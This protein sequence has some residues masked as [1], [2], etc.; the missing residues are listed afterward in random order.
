MAYAFLKHDEKAE[1]WIEVLRNIDISN[2]ILGPEKFTAI[3]RIHMA[4]KQCSQ[5]LSAIQN[6]EAKVSGFVTVFYDQ[7]FQE[8][9][10]FFILTKC[11][12]E[13]GKIYEAK[14]NYDQLLKHPQIKQVGGIYWSS[15][16]DRGRIARMEGKK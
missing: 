3:A 13:T 7:T 2:T 8:L 16:L 9:P 5:A 1:R 14:E 4:K 12:Y 15:L 10:K 6:S 11:Q